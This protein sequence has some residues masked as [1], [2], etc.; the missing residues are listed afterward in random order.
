MLIKL[1]DKTSNHL[2]ERLSVNMT[3]LPQ[4]LARSLT[5]DQGRELAGHRQFSVA[6]G[7]PVFFADPH[8]PWQRGTNEN[9]NGL[10]RQ[11]LPKGEDLSRYSQNQLDDIAALLNERP[12]KTLD[13]DTPAERFNQL[14]ATSA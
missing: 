6:T 10:V 9:W 3:R 12:R 14:V 5:W 7:I 2:T 11:F 4:H 8:S 1:K 13:W